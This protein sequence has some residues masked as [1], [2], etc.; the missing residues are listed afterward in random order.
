M[1]F[2]QDQLEQPLMHQGN[3]PRLALSPA[4]LELSLPFSLLNLSLFFPLKKETL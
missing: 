4:F 3:H 2:Q 1:D